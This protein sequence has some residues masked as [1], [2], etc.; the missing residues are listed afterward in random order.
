LIKT[1]KVEREEIPNAIVNAFES[2]QL[3]R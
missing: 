1:T 3:K 2:I